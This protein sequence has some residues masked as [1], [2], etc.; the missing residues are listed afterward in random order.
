MQIG[1]H[2][3]SCE[4]TVA[5]GQVTVREAGGQEHVREGWEITAVIREGYTIDVHYGISE[6]M[7]LR[8]FKR[9]TAELETALWRCRCDAIA[10]LMAPP[11]AKPLEALEARLQTEGWLYRYQDGLRWVP[12]EGVCFTRLYGELEGAELDERTYALTLRGPFGDNRLVRLARRTTELRHEVGQR[13][14]QARATFAESLKQA[15][16]AWRDEARVGTIRQHVPFAANK[17]RLAAVEQAEGLVA[18]ERRDYWEGLRDKA[19][20]ARLLVSSDEMGK[21]RLVALCPLARGELYEVVSE[22][23]H[24]SFVFRR[25]DPVVRAWTQVGFRREPIFEQEADGSGPYGALAALVPSLAQ[26]REAL[27]QRIIHDSVDSWREALSQA[28]EHSA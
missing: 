2:I 27:V 13:V 25:A 10:R 8:G 21:L 20:I 7:L 24:A 5:A 28:G 26:A 15:G 9:R 23:D 1:S 4:V 11:G 18:H 12:R 14:A 6:G 3:A 17:K 22:P 19:L 16:L